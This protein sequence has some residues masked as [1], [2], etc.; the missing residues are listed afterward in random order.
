[1]EFLC[2]ET[3][4]SNKKISMSGI[5]IHVPFCKKACHYCN[6]HFSTTAGYID[7]MVTAIRKEI[8]LRKKEVAPPI[9]TIYFEPQLFSEN[10]LFQ[11]EKYNFE[12][13]RID[14][15]IYEKVVYRGS[16]EGIFAIA[17]CKDLSF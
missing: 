17:K 15:K 10:D 8:L 11:F 5:Y 2:E 6:F 14:A 13:I 16:T 7:E 1:M 3:S 12:S 9:E 4:T